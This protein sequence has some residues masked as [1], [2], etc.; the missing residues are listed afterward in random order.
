MGDETA[1]E[2][3]TVLASDIFM[4][5]NSFLLKQFTHARTSYEEGMKRRRGRLC[6]T[7]TVSTVNLDNYYVTEAPYPRALTIIYVDTL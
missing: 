1:T 6:I 7:G 4:C 3:I 5:N 2:L